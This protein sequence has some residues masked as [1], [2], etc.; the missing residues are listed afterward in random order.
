MNEK[1]KN[2]D[3]IE[4]AL[5]PSVMPRKHIKIELDNLTK[6]KENSNS[7]VLEPIRINIAKD[8]DNIFLDSLHSLISIS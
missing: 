5:G 1:I 6:L 4:F 8:S 3:W 2:S 7:L